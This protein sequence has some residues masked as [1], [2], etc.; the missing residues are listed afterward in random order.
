MALPP[1]HAITIN[2]PITA[3]DF[4]EDNNGNCNFAALNCLKALLHHGFQNNSNP[5]SPVPCA[6]WLLLMSE[7][8]VACHNSLCTSH[9]TSINPVDFGQL[10]S[11]EIDAV[12]NLHLASKAISDYFKAPEDNHIWEQC[13][14]CLESC[15]MLV[16]KAA[17][18]SVAMT[19]R[20]NI[21]TI[22]ETIVNKEVYK[23]HAK[24]SEWSSTQF[25]QICNALIE[26]TVSD[27]TPLLLNMS[28]P[29]LVNWIAVVSNNLREHARAVLLDETVDKYTVPWATKCLDTARIHLLSNN[30][31][32]IHDSRAEAKHHAVDDAKAF[33]NS[34]FVAL[35]AEHLERARADALQA[36]DTKMNSFKHAL[37]IKVKEHKANAWSTI[38]Q[39]AP[40]VSRK[41]KSSKRHDPIGCH[42]HTASVASS[43]HPSPAPSI[44]PLPSTPIAQVVELLD[45]A[46]LDVTPKGSVFPAAHLKA[47]V[48]IEMAI[49]AATEAKAK[50]VFD[51]TSNAIAA[52]VTEQLKLFADKIDAHLTFS[53]GT[54]GSRLDALETTTPPPAGNWHGMDGIVPTSNAI[55]YSDLDAE[56]FKATHTSHFLPDMPAHAQML[57]PKHADLCSHA[58]D[59]FN[60]LHRTTLL[61]SNATEW[62]AFYDFILDA[63]TPT[64]LD[65][66]LL[67]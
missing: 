51:T 30:N 67:R 33:Y 29:C 23:L 31:N 61:D 63:F 11:D 17:W 53:L 46:P 49:D 32:A 14:C 47:Y 65:F 35:K 28:D 55:E 15:H 57:L 37:C 50:A 36:T 60:Q 19:C 22:H 4:T 2:V 20:Q 21:H 66:N 54:L 12:H 43:C 45:A 56:E 38:A 58:D 6:P 25:S 10:N 39:P 24:T 3:E 27:S 5:N 62:Q 48:P 9:G 42:S 34:T 41:G 16:D 13:L 26:S 64:C 18:E 40:S 1:P 44:L 7:L 59:I 8:L 52:F